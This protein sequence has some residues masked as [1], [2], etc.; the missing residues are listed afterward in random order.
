MCWP[1]YD[2][3]S[4]S[5]LV[6]RLNFWPLCSESY[7]IAK[8]YPGIFL[9]ADGAPNPALFPF[10]EAKFKLT[11]GDT[12]HIDEKT[13][14][15]IQ[16]YP[17]T[18]GWDN[19]SIISLF[20]LPH[21]FETFCLK[22]T[23]NPAQETAIRVKKLWV[24]CSQSLITFSWDMW[25]PLFPDQTIFD[26]LTS[27]FNH[28]HIHILSA[29]RNIHSIQVRYPGVLDIPDCTPKKE[30][31]CRGI[32]VVRRKRHSRFSFVFLH[33]KSW[34]KKTLHIQYKVSV[35]IFGQTRF[36]LKIIYKML[37]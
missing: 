5:L 11:N 32:F 27:I 36:A 34:C 7:R 15:R 24:Q 16:S 28:F 26:F 30:I 37:R 14:T 3:Y 20:R 25:H 21:L 23:T 6:I 1:D 8:G 35:V 17:D 19:F 22:P 31:L 29:Q 2:K 9:A 4:L 10:E 18:Y 33:F 13:M 12:I